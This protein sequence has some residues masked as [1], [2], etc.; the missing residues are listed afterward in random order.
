MLTPSV[1]W[2]LGGVRE[3]VGVGVLRRKLPGL[4]SWRSGEQDWEIF[5]STDA[6][7]F[8]PWVRVGRG[9]NAFFGR[10]FERVF[11]LSRGIC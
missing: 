8:F 3:G 9:G 5:Q 11:I 6:G 4:S 10:V 2:G 1:G 7:T